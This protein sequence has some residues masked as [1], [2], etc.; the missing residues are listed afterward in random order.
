MKIPLVAKAQVRIL[1]EGVTEPAQACD[2]LPIDLMPSRKFTEEQI[3]KGL[4]TP[5]PF[6]L[7]DLRCCFSHA[8]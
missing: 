6:G 7:A 8:I 5:G 1:S 3:R 4:P 2:P